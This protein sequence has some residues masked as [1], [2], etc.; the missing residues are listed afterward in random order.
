M[1]HCVVDGVRWEVEQTKDNCDELELIKTS[2][3]V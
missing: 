3:E 1:Q 2:F